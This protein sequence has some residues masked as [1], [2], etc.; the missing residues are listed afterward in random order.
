MTT[1]PIRSQ[2]RK[3]DASAFPPPPPHNTP[4]RAG[5]SPPAEPTVVA[6]RHDLSTLA[7]KVGANAAPPR[8]W[9][10]WNGHTEAA[11]TDSGSRSC[12]VT[13]IVTR[14]RLEKVLHRAAVAARLAAAV[15]C[16][17]SFSVLASDRD[18]GW[19]LDSYHRYKQYR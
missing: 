16:L 9:Y 11:P 19:A 1:E 13:G 3:E 14:G 12:V 8:D 7:A 4:I 18:K 6:S 15:L 10:P 17:V 5:T 2:L